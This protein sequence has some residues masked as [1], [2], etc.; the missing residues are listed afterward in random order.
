MRIA[1]ACNV[2]RFRLRLDPPPEAM[3][4]RSRQ[5]LTV[6]LGDDR[7][8]LARVDRPGEQMLDLTVP[9]ASLPLQLTL[10]TSPGW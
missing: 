7:S 9:N 8:I 10:E 4:L 2:E 5:H 1:T 6:E 3:T